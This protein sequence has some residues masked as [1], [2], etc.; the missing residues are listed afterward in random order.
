V[1]T[2]CT[3]TPYLIG[4]LPCF[5]EHIAWSESSA[6]TFVNSVI[7]ARTNREG[8]PS[9]IAAAIIGKTPAYG[10]HLETE[11]KPDLTFEVEADVSTLPDFGALGYFIGKQAEGKIPYIRGIK[12]ANVD[13]LK[14]F[15]ASVVTYGF[16][17]AIHDGGITPESLNHNPP[18][19]V[20]KVTEKELKESY[21]AL[22][23]DTGDIEFVSL[24]C[25]HCSIDEIGEI[26]RYLKGRR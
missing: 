20:I 4:N 11:R 3:C 21:K 19:K 17:A 2:C 13:K 26:A 25:P 12:S 5:G 23:D 9:A 18:K 1:I 10:L 15:S 16:K 22:N 8:G 24:G 6:V 14:S 7:G